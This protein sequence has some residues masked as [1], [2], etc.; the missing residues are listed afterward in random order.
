MMIR[1]GDEHIE[2]VSKIHMTS[3]NVNELS[4]KLGSG[5]VR[6]FYK[7]IVDSKYSF[8]FVYL[9]ENEVIGYATGFYD[10]HLFN[11]SLKNENFFFLVVTL[12]QRMVAGK[13]KTNDLTNLLQDDHKLKR[14]KYPK[15]HLGALALANEYKGTDQG[16][17]A[18]SG[19]ICSV[20]AELS[21]KGCPG[22]FATCDCIN[23]PMRKRILKLGFE[24]VDIIPMKGRRVVLYEKSF[25]NE[26]VIQ[27]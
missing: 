10:Y 9:E 18:I 22:C 14:S 26:S 7:H 23:V 3:W 15:Y 25:Q 24:E 6:R 12:I 27:N 4:V 1:M 21:E 8:G 17:K 11:Q 13:I 2:S 16:K 20:L 19:V 5:Y